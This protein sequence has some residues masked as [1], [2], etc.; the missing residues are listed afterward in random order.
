MK[1]EIKSDH[2]L[3]LNR[4]FSF[5]AIFFG[6]MIGLMLMALMMYLDAVL[7]LDAN[8]A[9]IASM[10]G[11][12]L[13]PLFGGP[14]NRRE[15][16]LMQTCATATTFA[17]YSLTGN[18]VPL[19]MMGEKLEILPV[20]VLLLLSD[21][22]GICFVSILRDQFVYDKNLPFPGAVMCLTAMDQIGTKDKS[23]TKLLF[24]AVVFS[25]AVS[26]LQNMQYMPVMADFTSGLPNNGMTLGVLIMPLTLGMGYVVGSRNALCMLVTNL[27]VCLIEAPV[28]TSRAWFANPA[29]NFSGIQDFNLPMVI[30]IALM[31]ALIP[32]GRQWRTIVGAF[33][34]KKGLEEKSDRDYSLKPVLLLL[35]VLSASMI[36]FCSYYYHIKVVHMIICSVLSLIF[37]MVAIR[38]HAE[39]GLSAGLAL[40][41][42]MIVIAYGL[43]GNAAF[44]MLIA[45]MSFNT[46]VLAQDT[47]Y[48]LKTGQVVGASSRKLI[49]AQFIG[50]I[51]GCVAG[52]ALFYGIIQVFGLNDELF[53]FPFGRMYYSIASGISEGG[54]SSMFN[55]GRFAAGGALGAILSVIGL[56]AGGIALAMYLA[57]T[58]VMGIALGGII[59]L[60]VEKTKGKEYAGKMNNVATGLVIGDAMVCILMVIISMITH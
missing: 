8:A 48:D 41:I 31:A 38:V 3:S 18:L 56:P 28:G 35:L 36:G 57:P 29:E 51:C 60:V 16:N 45:F 37:A 58:T 54:V 34:F 43:T 26:F 59:R 25:V 14:T 55:P 39:S 42:F 6:V 13:I 17:A 46:F 1:K 12:L 19:L 50:I 40:N 22:I 47:M 11:V 44:A 15:V 20:F 9:P 32:I 27:L 33:R 24:G 53:T 7:G 49:K 4:E 21:A 2:E 23:S 30:G 10:I 5:R 52:T